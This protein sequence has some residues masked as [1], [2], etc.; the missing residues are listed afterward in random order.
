LSWFRRL[1]GGATEPEVPADPLD[2][3]RPLIDGGASSFDGS[4]AQSRLARAPAAERLLVLR[5]WRERA[6]AHPPLLRALADLGGE[7]ATELWVTLAG[8]ADLD[9]AT[10]GAAE[11]ALADVAEAAGRPDDAATHLQRAA[12]HLPEDGAL[13]RRA[14]GASRH[15]PGLPDAAM[16]TAAHRAEQVLALPPIPDRLPTGLVLGRRLGSGSFGVV[17]AARDTGLGRDV[18]VKLL[19]PH[20]AADPRRVRAFTEEARLLAKLGHPGVV[21]LYDIDAV[22][23]AIVMEL[24]PEGSLRD[25]LSVVGRF[26]PADA[27]D[28][29]RRLLEILADLHPLGVVHGDL[30]PENLLFRAGRSLALG[31]FGVGAAMAGTP[32]YRAPEQAEGGPPDPRHD[33]HAVG[34]IWLELLSGVAPDEPV[35]WEPASE[36]ARGTDGDPVSR[37]DALPAL[38]LAMCAPDPADRPADATV[39]LSA[40]V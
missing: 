38:A 31:D 35:P 25:R 4:E 12:A 30:K 3:W 17:H 39:A 40:L 11:R 23:H 24:C 36:V 14:L 34:R 32:G 15:R 5:R 29:V 27:L 21:Y 28:L 16:H 10:R 33:V 1:F 7:E 9:R 22:T 18:A 26:E 2:G 20:H 37:P 19:H 13:L 6:P 8:R